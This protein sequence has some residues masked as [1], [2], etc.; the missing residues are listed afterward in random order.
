M[1]RVRLAL[2]ALGVA[3]LAAT[4]TAA[5]AT[6]TAAGATFA[7]AGATSSPAGL[8]YM[9]GSLIRGPTSVSVAAANGANRHRLGVGFSPALS[10][11]GRLVAAAP[12]AGSAVIVYSSSG[13]VVG[14]FF[15]A[16]RYSAHTFAWSPGSR[17]LAVVLQ[18]ATGSHSGPCLVVIDART[19][20]AKT[21]VSGWV[22]GVSFAP[23]GP[24]RLVF[25]LGRSGNGSSNLYTAAATGG[26]VKQLTHDG[27][28]LNPVW[29]AR[30]IVFDHETPRTRYGLPSYPAY[31]L[32]LLAGSR[33]TQITH[34]NVFWEGEGLIPVAISADGTKLAA[35]WFGED[36][37]QGWSVNLVTHALRELSTGFTANGISRD[38]RRVLIDTMYGLDWSPATSRI[39]TVPFSGGPATVLVVPGG[40]AS[41]NQ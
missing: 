12:P 11:N 2:I 13:A 25:G 33:L 6:S 22:Q 3:L 7:A 34:M 17:Y 38:G 1:I 23:S 28:S 37:D 16:G 14:K 21:I 8:A 41:W 40:G 27:V 5:G 36:M 15:D 10:P 39:E 32:Y 9:T 20:Q 35:N 18:P 31:Q 26:T 30:G 24:N 19:K 4:S 29:G